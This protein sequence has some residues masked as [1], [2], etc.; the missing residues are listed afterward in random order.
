M[1][2]VWNKSVLFA[3]IV[4]CMTGV[5][6]A[7]D[8]AVSL[9]YA[10]RTFSMSPSDR[11]I[12]DATL[13]PQLPLGG[14]MYASGLIVDCMTPH[15]TSIMLNPPPSLRA[16]RV[17]VSPSRLPVAVPHPINDPAAHEPDFALLRISFP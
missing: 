14:D 13:E 12:W 16:L 15:F 1:R 8:K 5:A 17:Q 4:T 11:I 3:V 7:Q 9:Q 2:G 10:T 6:M